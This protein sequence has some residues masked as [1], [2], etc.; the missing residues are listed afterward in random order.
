[1]GRAPEEPAAFGPVQKKQAP[2]LSVS[3][4][5][6]SIAFAPA[7]FSRFCSD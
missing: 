3:S 6:F 1:M 4:L 5:T 2:A 7:G